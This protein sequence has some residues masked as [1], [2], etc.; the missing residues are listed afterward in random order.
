MERGS[1]TVIICSDGSALESQTDG[2]RDGARDRKGSLGKGAWR[3]AGKKTRRDWSREHAP[4]GVKEA[5]YL[6]ASSHFI[7]HARR[8]VSTAS[9]SFPLSFLFR[10]FGDLSHDERDRADGRC[11]CVVFDFS[12]PEVQGQFRVSTPEVQDQHV[13]SSGSLRVQPQLC[14]CVRGS[15]CVA[16]SLFHVLCV[17]VWVCDRQID[18]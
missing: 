13:R 14:V 2:A 7:P 5:T 6:P 12:T 4:A 10:L 3:H 15:L 16:V 8:G 1:M 18:R 9:F 11:G 17:G